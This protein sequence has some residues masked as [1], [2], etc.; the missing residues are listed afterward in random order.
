MGWGWGVFRRDR[1]KGGAAS[2][3]HRDIWK[4]CLVKVCQ[5]KSQ[6][7][8]EPSTALKTQRPRSSLVSPQSEEENSKQQHTDSTVIGPL[9]VPRYYW[10]Y[11][12]GRE[13]LET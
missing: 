11:G 4:V 8:P 6:S 9:C 3:H 10:I 5:S 13:K 2:Y 7:L 12:V 1:S